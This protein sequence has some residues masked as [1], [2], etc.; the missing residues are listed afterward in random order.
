LLLIIRVLVADNVFH[1]FS[2]EKKNRASDKEK[3][4]N[5]DKDLTKKRFEFFYI[6]NHKNRFYLIKI[7]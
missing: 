5:K 2:T 3:K 1:L 7:I 4:A 6:I